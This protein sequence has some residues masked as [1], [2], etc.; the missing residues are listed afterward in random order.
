MVSIAGNFFLL[1]QFISSQG[2][3]LLLAISWILVL[4][5]VLL[6]D[7]TICLNDFQSSRVLDSLYLLKDQLQSSFHHFLECLVM[8]TFL[9]LENQACSSPTAS[10]LTICFSDSQFVIDEVLR[11]LNMEMTTLTNF[12]S[13]LLFLGIMSLE[14]WMN[15]SIM[16]MVIVRGT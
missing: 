10:E 15:S 8:L 14:N 12:S 13:S 1:T 6:V 2:P 7:L 9:V 16:G 3:Q 11:D 4:K 5:N